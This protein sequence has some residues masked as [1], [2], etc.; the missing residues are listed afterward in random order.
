MDRCRSD[1]VTEPV[2]L[3]FDD[4]PDRNW[5]PH[6]LDLLAAAGMHATFFVI[7]ERAQLEPDLIRRIDA[8]GHTIGNHTYSHRHPWFMTAKAARAQVR[9]AAAALEDMLGYPPRLFRPPHG[10]HRECMSDEARRRG[11]H[12]VLWNLSA[13]DWG[14]FG[15]AARIMRRLRQVG[16]NDVV[17]MHD[18]RNRHNRPD[19][20][21]KALP[22]FLF[23]LQRRGLHSC[24]LPA[25]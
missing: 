14:M 25:Q 19:Q 24:R 3:T 21:L 5:T 6:I 22:G 13:V 11:E 18:G 23:E 7:A 17:L 20:L 9:D 4:G 10:R 15:T 12:V 16:A 2:Y 8:A 1:F